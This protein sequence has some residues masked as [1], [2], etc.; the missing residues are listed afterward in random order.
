[1]YCICDN[2][3]NN[4]ILVGTLCFFIGPTPM[5]SSPS[6]SKQWQLLHNY[7]FFSPSKRQKLYGTN[8]MPTQSKL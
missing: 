1:M 7:T 5:I 6:W 2:K 3:D 4:M 8:G